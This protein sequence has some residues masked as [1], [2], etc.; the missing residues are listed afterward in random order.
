M[1]MPDSFE[2][3]DMRQIHNNPQ[4]EKASDATQ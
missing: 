2:Y 1:K 3:Q 4:S